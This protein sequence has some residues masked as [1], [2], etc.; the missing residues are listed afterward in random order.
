[1]NEDI[2]KII[3]DARH[4]KGFSQ[5]MVAKLAGTSQQVVNNIENNINA[6]SLFLPE[7]CRV[8]GVNLFNL[9]D[10]K[11]ADSGD[12]IRSLNLDLE[13]LNII[14]DSVINTLLK[15]ATTAQDAE[16]DF[17]LDEGNAIALGNVLIAQLVTDVNV[18]LASMHSGRKVD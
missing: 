15:L 16:T 9:T 13:E 14:S 7:V 4:N 12:G 2:C 5:A 11:R 3:R 17:K 18:N 6:R 8:L 10:V 1:M